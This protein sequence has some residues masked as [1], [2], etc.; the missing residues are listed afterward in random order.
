MGRTLV[1]GEHP[2]GLFTLGR[3]GIRSWKHCAELHFESFTRRTTKI[4]PP[5]AK[6]FSSVPGS[7]SPSS[8]ARMA[9]KHCDTFRPWTGGKFRTSS[10]LI[11]ICPTS[12]AWGALRWL[13][14]GHATRDIPIYLLTS[15]NEPE[16][17][18][19]SAADGV[20]GYLLKSPFFDDVIR[21]LDRQ[22][23]LINHQNLRKKHVGPTGDDEPFVLVGE[24]AYLEG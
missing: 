6:Y 21:S 18:R 22:I 14:H 7:S 9:W 19:R 23:E 10:C 4:L 13:R 8:I 12:M 20:T 24:D 16:D 1:W 5:S 2:I 3:Q 11:F 17:R 15:S